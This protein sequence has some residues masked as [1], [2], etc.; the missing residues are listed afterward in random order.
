MILV[1]IPSRHEAA[2]FIRRLDGATSAKP[3]GETRVTQGRLHGRTV[4]VAEVGMGAAV[5][6][7]RTQSVLTALPPPSVVW[8]A[9]YGGALD[10]TLR[11]GQIAVWERT[12]GSLPTAAS[13]PEHR[14]LQ[15]LHTAAE[16]VATPRH[17]EQLYRST[18]CAIVEMEAEAVFAVTDFRKLP[19]AAVRAVSDTAD[20]PLPA[21][22]LACGY[23][24]RR[25][26][27]TPLRMVWRLLTHPSDI[28]RLRAF[29]SGL[30][31]VRRALADFL[32]EAVRCHAGSGR[33]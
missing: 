10:P 18:G 12:P 14:R 11:R 16:V 13:L 19:A 32:E 21:E 2:D 20:E 30:P 8:L 7:R 25:G 31:P 4:A 3:D 22:L 17:K 23:D 9:G 27:E 29:L 24:M 6:S 33:A 28:G 15:Y 5:A 26:R 1:L